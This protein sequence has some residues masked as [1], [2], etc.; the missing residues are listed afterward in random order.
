[1][2]NLLIMHGTAA[3]SLGTVVACQIMRLNERM[4]RVP[5]TVSN[6]AILF[7][8]DDFKIKAEGKS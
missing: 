1:M 4:F 8:G 5:N 6:H 7:C 2:E 3:V